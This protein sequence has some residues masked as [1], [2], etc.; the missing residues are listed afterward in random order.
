MGFVC[1]W[2]FLCVF[3]V[4][5]GFFVWFLGGCCC[6]FLGFHELSNVDISEH[7]ITLR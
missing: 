6:C 7:I 2:G 5:V 1:V 3:F 4:V